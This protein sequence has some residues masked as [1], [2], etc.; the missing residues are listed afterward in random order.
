MG[1]WSFTLKCLGLA[2]HDVE[3]NWDALERFAPSNQVGYLLATLVIG[4]FAVLTW[5]APRRP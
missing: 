1:S 2:N 4:A 3:R 5:S